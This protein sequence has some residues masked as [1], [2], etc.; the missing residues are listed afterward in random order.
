[1][2]RVKW[3]SMLE[4]TSVRIGYRN[5]IDAK[6][7]IS[8]DAKHFHLLGFF[9]EASMLWGFEASMLRLAILNSGMGAATWFFSDFGQQLLQT[10][11]INNV[12]DLTCLLSSIPSWLT[13]PGLHLQRLESTATTSNHQFIG[14]STVLSAEHQ[15]YHKCILSSNWNYLI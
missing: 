11:W 2:T 9:K 13:V 4:F 6:S 5:S 8:I 14:F 10:S 12:M 7:K 1:M 3:V 15:N